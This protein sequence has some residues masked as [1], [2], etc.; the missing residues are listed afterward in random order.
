MNPISAYVVTSFI[1]SFY[2][3]S[4]LAVASSTL[5]GKSV[6]ILDNKLSATCDQII[7][8]INAFNNI[9]KSA[10]MEKLLEKNIEKRTAIREIHW[11]LKEGYIREFSNGNLTIS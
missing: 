10:L 4:L 8:K 6:F 5:L 7:T 3:F 1:N 9:K 2:L 11:L